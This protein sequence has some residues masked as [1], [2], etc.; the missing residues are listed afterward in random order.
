MNDPAQIR[1]ALAQFTG[2]QDYHRWS[3]L[4]RHTVLTDGALCLAEK[5]GA[6]WLCDVIASHQPNRK[7]QAACRGL[8]FWKVVEDGKGGCVVTCDDGNGNIA[9]TQRVPFTDFPFSAFED[10]TARVYVADQQV[11]DEAL[12]VVMLPGE[13]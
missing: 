13:Y 5:C 1:A 9:L 2:T 12:K 8:Q 4:F 11:G 10:G 7:M 3:G 6:F